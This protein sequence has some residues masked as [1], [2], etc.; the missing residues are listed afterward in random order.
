MRRLL[1]ICLA[2]AV[3]ALAVLVGRRLLEQEQ[4]MSA[5][6]PPPSASNGAGATR[7]ELYREARELG[8]EGRSKMNKE[9]LQKAV[10]AARTGGRT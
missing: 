8:V 10:E 6:P 3:A 5:P 7:D 9:Q 1:K 4:E 2:G